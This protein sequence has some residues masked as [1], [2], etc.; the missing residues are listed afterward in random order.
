MPRSVHA[1]T[2]APLRSFQE[3]MSFC[4]NLLHIVGEPCLNSDYESVDA[5]RIVPCWGAISCAVEEVQ[6]V[7]MQ[8]SSPGQVKCGCPPRIKYMCPLQ[9]LLG[10]GDIRVGLY[11][12]FSFYRIPGYSGDPLRFT[13]SCLI[14]MVN[15]KPVNAPSRLH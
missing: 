14:K 7:Y 3:G 8:C 9:C 12:S 10:Y 6:Q 4:S 2:P 5:G 11:P 13:K 15:C 1:I